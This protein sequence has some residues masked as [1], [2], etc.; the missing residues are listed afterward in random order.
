MRLINFQ[1][2]KERN[3]KY[4]KYDNMI[5]SMA[6]KSRLFK[7]KIDKMQKHGILAPT[8][9]F[10][11]KNLKR[12]LGILLNKT[13]IIKDGNGEEPNYYDA[14]DPFIDDGEIVI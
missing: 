7:I 12:D 2:S 11:R 10:C 8:Q 3:K 6:C 14:D 4:Y 5:N 1:K 13:I 9:E